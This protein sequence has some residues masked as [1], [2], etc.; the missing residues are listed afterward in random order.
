MKLLTLGQKVIVLLVVL[1]ISMRPLLAQQESGPDTY[2]QGKADGERD[3][4]GNV[5]WVA[6]GVLFPWGNL[7]AYLMKPGPPAHAF[8][9]KSSQYILGYKEG[10]KNKAALKNLKYSCIG[11]GVVMAIVLVAAATEDGSNCGPNF[12]PKFDCSNACENSGDSCIGTGDSSCG[13]GDGSGGWSR[14]LPVR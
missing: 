1:S 14:I 5:L 12:E 8:I 3:A 13:G 7:A 4:K 6:A 10:Y 9:G 11:S 2:L